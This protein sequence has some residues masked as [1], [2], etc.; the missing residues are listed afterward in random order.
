MTNVNYKFLCNLETPS[1]NHKKLVPRQ[2]S[3]VRSRACKLGN[4]KA[5][6]FGLGK[7]TF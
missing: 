3:T 1:K 2:D 5:M 6:L 4:L 7:S